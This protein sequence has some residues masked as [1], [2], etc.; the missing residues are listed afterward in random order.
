MNK[1][2]IKIYLQ[3]EIHIW[4]QLINKIWRKLRKTKNALKVASQCIKNNPKKKLRLIHNKSKNKK[5]L[6]NR[7]LK[8]KF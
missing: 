3:M 7:K 8:R 4:D 5:N 6:L 2:K 1:R